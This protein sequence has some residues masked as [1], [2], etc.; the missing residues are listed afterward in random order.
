[1][2]AVLYRLRCVLRAQWRVTATL[3]TIVA[4]LVGLVLTLAAGA[5][6]TLDAPDRY[7]AGR[8]SSYDAL[9]YQLSERGQRSRAG[10]VARLGGVAAVETITFVFGAMSKRGEA[11]DSSLQATVFSGG[12]G[13]TGERLVAGREADSTLENEFVASSSFVAA[14]DASLGDEFDLATLTEASAQA[15]GFDTTQPSGTALRAVLV[16]V[17]NGPSELDDPTPF[18]VFSPALLV[19][20]AHIGVALSIISVRLERGDR[21][22]GPSTTDHCDAGSAQRIRLATI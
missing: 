22:R 10:E 16:G 9:I 2:S 5:R 21:S 14:W 13:P 3:A 12:I 17:I 8:G 19:N 1:M 4:L 11:P 18:V 15:G 7:V 20:D 6:R